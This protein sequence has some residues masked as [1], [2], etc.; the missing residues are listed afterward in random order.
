MVVAVAL[1]IQKRWE[2]KGGA[3]GRS[4]HAGTLL[5]CLVV[6]QAAAAREV[7]RINEA[8]KCS[9]CLSSH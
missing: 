7:A 3:S 8:H 6:R 5:S 9:G 1:L 2:A 4:A